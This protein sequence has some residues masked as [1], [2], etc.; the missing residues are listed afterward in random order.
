MASL[1]ERQR[2]HV[3]FTWS[4]QE[5]AVP[6]SIVDGK[7]AVFTDEDGQRW[8]D[9]ESQVF[10]CNLGHGED[11]VVEA[12]QA[13]AAQLGVAHPAAVYPAKVALGEALSRI[14]PDGLEKFFGF[15]KG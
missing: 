15:R 13:Q 14:T 1:E 10:N 11:R 8:L 12:I 7:G 9:F 3:F 2:K 5:K 6:V 4:A